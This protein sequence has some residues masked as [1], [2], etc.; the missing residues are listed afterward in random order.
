MNGGDNEKFFS[1]KWSNGRLLILNKLGLNKLE[2]I[3]GLK[4]FRGVALPVCYAFV[5]PNFSTRG[6]STAR[7]I[8]RLLECHQYIFFTFPPGC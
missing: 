8:P 3:G 1:I 5:I 4:N 6:N 2:Q 7:N